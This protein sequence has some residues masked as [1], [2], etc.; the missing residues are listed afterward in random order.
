ML[1]RNHNMLN[2]E[3]GRLQQQITSGSSG[4]KY[5]QE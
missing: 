4:V 5:E 2:T 1:N 3:V